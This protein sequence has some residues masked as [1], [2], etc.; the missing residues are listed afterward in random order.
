MGTM[1]GAST[2]YYTFGVLKDGKMH[3][4]MW[5]VPELIMEKE[6]VDDL[7]QCFEEVIIYNEKKKKNTEEQVQT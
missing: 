3:K 7:D 4:E 6:M 5:L 1:G 2:N